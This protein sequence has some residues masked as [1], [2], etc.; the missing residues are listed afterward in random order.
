[1]VPP[2]NYH[3][4]GGGTMILRPRVNGPVLFLM[5]LIGCA[6]FSKQPGIGPYNGA[7]APAIE[8]TDSQGRAM[9]LADYRGKV[10]LLSFWHYG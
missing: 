10:V 6:P 2:S 3:G 9:R 8:G 5:L 7:I 1:M 4:E